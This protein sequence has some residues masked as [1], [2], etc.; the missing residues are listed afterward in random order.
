MRDA[1]N[2]LGEM[3]S[4]CT[5]MSTLRIV[6]LRNGIFMENELIAWFPVSF[7]PDYR[8]K[9]ERFAGVAT[10]EK[11][12]V[13]E[14]DARAYWKKLGREAERHYEDAVASFRAIGVGLSDR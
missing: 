2:H 5:E 6:S 12:G 1:L 11:S 4:D 9:A 8:E 3:A 13:K 14:F 7:F 10:R